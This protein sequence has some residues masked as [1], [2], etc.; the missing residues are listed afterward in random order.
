MKLKKNIKFLK[1][2][3]I[4]AMVKRD[5]LAYPFDQI[6]FWNTTATHL[7]I[8]QTP[9]NISK[10]P[11]ISFYCLE[12]FKIYSEKNNAGHR[13]SKKQPWELD[14]YITWIVHIKQGNLPSDLV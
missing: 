3:S 6:I 13:I 12:C 8:S 14:M 11:Y 1:Y 2:L 10:N 9:L 5:F 4:P 7:P